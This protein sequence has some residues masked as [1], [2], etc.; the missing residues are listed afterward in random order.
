MQRKFGA[1]GGAPASRNI[2]DS[3]DQA[4]LGKGISWAQL[5]ESQRILLVA[6][7]G[8]GKT[9]ECK[10]QTKLLFESGEAAFFLRLEEVAA[11]GVRLCL[12]GEQQKRFDDWRASASQMGYFFLDSIDELQ[13]AHADF[14]DAL[15]RL[16]HDL[17]GGWGRAIIVVT[18]RPVDIDRKAFAELLPVPKAVTDGG[19]EE[20]FVRIAVEGRVAGDENLPPLF[21]EVCLLAL[22]DE[23]IMEFAGGQGV[24]KPDELLAAIHARHAGD[25]ARRPQ[26]LI[27][28][29][30][31]WRDHHQIRAHFEQIKS[32][33]RARLIARADRQEKA[34]L[35]LDKA[36][37]GAQRLALAAILSRRL[38]IRHSAGADVEGSG[39]VPV[40][41][42]ELLSDWTAEVAPLVRTPK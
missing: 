32:H 37:V 2:F 22:S 12:Y 1:I 33:I 18:S 17:E 15:E 24:V 11:N 34:D 28:L 40:I 13:L 30:D 31:D 20:E 29:C 39:D 16:G 42:S 7:A 36:R 10:T 3:R 26:D 27:E 6:E 23:E 25:F 8:A 35:T 4:H 19:H 5:L 9:H 21:R 41:P 38:T 14:R